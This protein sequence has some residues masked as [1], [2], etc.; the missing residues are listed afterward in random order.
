M[1]EKLKELYG[2]QVRVTTSDGII[3]GK[4]CI[5]ERAGDNEYECDSI[6]IESDLNNLIEI[7]INEINEIEEINL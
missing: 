5:Y 6:S 3:T 2:K 7:K 4:F 1:I